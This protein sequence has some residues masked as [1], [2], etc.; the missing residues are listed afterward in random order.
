MCSICA[1]IPDHL[2]AN[3]GR[4]EYLPSTTTPL[5]A[6]DWDQDADLWR[7]PECGDFYF[8]TEYVAQ[9]GSGNND[10]DTLTRL[11]PAV[12]TAMRAIIDRKESIEQH[13]S[14]ID[15]SRAGR[16]IR[17]RLQR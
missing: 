9:T 4:S 15:P 3:T 14:V 7:C 10:E 8:Y 5:V 11:E 13:A 1:Q 16:F 17:D 6:L 2:V 12:Q